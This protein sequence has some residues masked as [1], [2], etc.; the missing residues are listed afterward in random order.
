MSR[1]EGEHAW[2]DILWWFVDMF[3]GEIVH[4]NRDGE[5]WLKRTM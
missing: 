1:R 3:T 5:T 2:Q 4:D